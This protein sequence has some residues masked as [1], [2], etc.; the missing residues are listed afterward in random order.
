MSAFWMARHAID[1][2]WIF[3]HQEFKW[4]FTLFYGS[5]KCLIRLLESQ[6]SEKWKELEQERFDNAPIEGYNIPTQQ[7]CAMWEQSKH[8]FLRAVG[9]V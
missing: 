6:R 9:R 3:Y 8:P 7:F 2:Q 5:F 1:P 4:T